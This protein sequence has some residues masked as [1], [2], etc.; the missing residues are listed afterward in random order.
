MQCKIQLQMKH[1]NGFYKPQVFHEYCDNMC[2]IYNAILIGLSYSTYIKCVTFVKFRFKVKVLN[3]P[4]NTIRLV[5]FKQM[6]Y[7]IFFFN[8]K[9]VVRSRN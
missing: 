4:T 8:N 6:K 5:L 2:L 9:C 7:N 3:L 1:V